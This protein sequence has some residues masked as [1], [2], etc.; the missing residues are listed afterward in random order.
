MKYLS[1]ALFFLLIFGASR[2]A[3]AIIVKI[4]TAYADSIYYGKDINGNYIGASNVTNPESSLGKPD[5]K[6]AAFGESTALLD[7]AFRNYPHTDTIH[8]RP[9]AT[10]FIWGKVDKTVDSS[11][12]QVTL[13]RFDFSGSLFTSKPFILGDGLNII[14]VPPGQDWAFLEFSLAAPVDHGSKNHAKSYFLDA[15]AVVED[16]SHPPINFVSNTTTLSGSMISY[17]NP[18][19]ENTTIRFTT[20][21]GGDAELIIIDALGREVDRVNAGYA[22]SGAHEIPLAIKTPGF[23]FV[24][25]FVNG[26]PVGAPLKISSR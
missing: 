2:N 1:A 10:L 18:F 24:R 26:Q 8:I 17:P 9:N 15:I 23:Y 4:D 20:E 13:N 11:A 19:I 25:L 7:L 6:V 21:T 3:H 16:T 14:Q 22:E 5:D 12:G